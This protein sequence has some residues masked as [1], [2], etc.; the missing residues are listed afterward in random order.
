[1]VLFV[2]GKEGLFQ[3][4]RVLIWGGDVPGDLQVV[5]IAELSMDSLAG[6]LG[7]TGTEVEPNP[8]SQ[9]V[10]VAG[11]A[12]ADDVREAPKAAK[13]CAGPNGIDSRLTR[14]AGQELFFGAEPERVPSGYSV[15][16][17]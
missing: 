4:S 9:P 12:D 3:G 16:V 7:R 5:E 10:L 6:I 14:Q 13:R 8:S 2:L 17:Q 11:R 15:G 1:M